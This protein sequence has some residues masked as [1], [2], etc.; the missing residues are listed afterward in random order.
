MQDVTSREKEQYYTCIAITLVFIYQRSYSIP[1]LQA[2]ETLRSMLH[3]E[4]CLPEKLVIVSSDFKRAGE[5]ADILHSQLQVKTPLR[6]EPGIRARDF[7]RL[8]MTETENYRRVWDL[9]A[10]DP[11]HTDFGNESLMDIVMRASRFIQSLDEEFT[12]KI[13]VLVSHGDVL[14]IVSTLFLGLSPSEYTTLPELYNCEIRELK[15]VVQ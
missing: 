7:G 6:L 5:T 9:D 15:E 13:I 3:S 12:D 2:S 8:H 14:R 11:T 10:V 1:I 4:H